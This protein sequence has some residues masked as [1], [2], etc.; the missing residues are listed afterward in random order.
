ME[1]QRCNATIA[2]LPHFLIKCVRSR[3]ALAVWKVVRKVWPI[4]K[5]V[6]PLMMTTRT[7]V[8]S[9]REQ[10]HLCTI[11][12]NLRRLSPSIRGSHRRRSVLRRS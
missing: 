4:H 12:R 9:V 1:W 10:I 6:Q 5:G 3:I 7:N 8:A 11:A 2:S